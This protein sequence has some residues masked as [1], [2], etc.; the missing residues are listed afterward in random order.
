MSEHSLVFYRISE[1]I[2]PCSGSTVASWDQRPN[3]IRD[4]HI[5]FRILKT[6]GKKICIRNLE[7]LAKT[8]SMSV[9]RLMSR[10]Q[11]VRPCHS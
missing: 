5:A 1:V 2:F 6:A 3:S 4:F 11:P 9:S 8:F 7:L 10:L